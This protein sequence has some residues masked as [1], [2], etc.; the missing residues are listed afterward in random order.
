MIIEPTFKISQKVWLIDDE[1][2]ILCICDKCGTEHLS[3]RKWTIDGNSPLRVADWYGSVHMDSKELG[4]NYFLGKKERIQACPENMFLTK[5][6]AQAECE[7]R[8]EK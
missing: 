5:K 3:R 4:E 6:E 1:E 8:N 7:K 2:M